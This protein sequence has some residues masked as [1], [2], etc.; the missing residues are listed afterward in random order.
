MPFPFSL[1]SILSW[2]LYFKRKQFLYLDL[3]IGNPAESHRH[4]GRCIIFCKAFSIAAA[5]SCKVFLAT[6]KADQ[7]TFVNH[8]IESGSRFS[9]KSCA[10]SGEYC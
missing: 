6:K 4:S 3:N 8:P 1:V 9:E 7:N 5:V 2:S 10:G